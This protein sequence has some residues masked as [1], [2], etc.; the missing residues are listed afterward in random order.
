MISSPPYALATPS[1]PYRAL[2][3]LAGR[4]QI[5]GDREIALAALLAARLADGMLPPHPLSR[6]TR[7]VRAAAARAWF[8][9]LTVQAAVRLPFLRLVDATAGTDPTAAAR[10]LA[11]VHELLAAQ[12]DAAASAELHDLGRRLADTP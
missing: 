4:A 11:A 12:L 2:A 5:G 3:G 10:Q 6:E 9:S 7:A 8:A 1:F